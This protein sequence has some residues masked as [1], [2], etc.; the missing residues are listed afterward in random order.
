MQRSAGVSIEDVRKSTFHYFLERFA[1]RTIEEIP[2]LLLSSRLNAN[3]NLYILVFFFIGLS[4][5]IT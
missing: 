5:C 4:V 2:T 3:L 1:V